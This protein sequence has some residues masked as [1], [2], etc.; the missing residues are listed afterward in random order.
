MADL[1]VQVILILIA[2][3]FLAGFVDSIA[4]GGGLITVPA[5]LLAGIPPVDALAT[6]KVQGSFGSGTAAFTYARAGLIN[7]RTQWL[8]ALLTAALAGLGALTAS[9]LPTEVIRKALPVIL[10]GIALFFAFKPG[11]DDSDRTARMPP[12]AFMLF[13]APLIGFYDGIAGPGTGSFLMLGFVLLAGYGMLKATAATKLLNFASNVGSLA[14]F[15]LV[16]SPLWLIG[17]L[18]GAA[19]MAGAI[20]GSK[21]AI[22]NG[23]RVIRPLLVV[24]SL[25]LALKLLLG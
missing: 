21:L 22:R 5:L 11:L 1:S 4:G 25:G 17:I 16:S 14:V 15:A 3:G 7:P 20:V 24:T 8:P 6:N 23:A 18:M 13:V 12:M 2:A 10:I 19:Q 9:Y